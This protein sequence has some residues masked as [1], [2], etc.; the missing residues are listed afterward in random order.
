MRPNGTTGTLAVAAALLLAVTLA[1][2]AHAG[3]TAPDFTLKDIDGNS[4][5]LS[6]YLGD[7]V[8]VVSFWA[9]WC[10]PCKAEMPHLDAMYKDL[11]DQGLIVLAISVDEARDA[12]KAKQQAKAAGYSF[13]VLLDQATEVVTL[14]NP[15][16][17]VPFTAIIGKDKK[18]H[19]THVGYSPGDETKLRAEVEALLGVGDAPDAG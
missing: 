7:K 18:I 12:P 5:S 4:V 9:T 2:L 15:S 1:P 3:G 10:S 6:D 13:P 11:G 14:F 8:I 17:S 19:A 16:K